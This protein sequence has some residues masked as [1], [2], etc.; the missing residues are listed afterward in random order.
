M[1]K[2]QVIEIL[3]SQNAKRDLCVQ[4]ADAFMEYQEST[5]NIE[6]N[7]LIV[8]HPRTMNPMDNPYMSVRDRAL[9]KLQGLRKVNA[10]GLW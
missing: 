3:L 6:E 10:V 9:K 8:Q 1:T 7:G 5:K 4:Y 2:D